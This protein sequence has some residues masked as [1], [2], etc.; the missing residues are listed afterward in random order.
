ML[1]TEGKQTNASSTDADVSTLKAA[2][3]YIPYVC[4]GGATSVDVRAIDSGACFKS[5]VAGGWTLNT[6]GNLVLSFTRDSVHQSCLSAGLSKLRPETPVT[7]PYKKYR[8]CVLSGSAFYAARYGQSDA[9]IMLSADAP[10]RIFHPTKLNTYPKD[11]SLSGCSTV[12][13]AQLSR[14]EPKSTLHFGDESR[15]Y[16]KEIPMPTR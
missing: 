13:A 4:V 3:E 2:Y 5:G 9:M 1:Q 12:N 11:R 8:P 6:I 15:R 16:Q 7:P 10:T 14:M